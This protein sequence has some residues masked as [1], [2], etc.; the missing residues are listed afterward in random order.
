MFRAVRYK[1]VKSETQTS[2]WIVAL[3]F[4][5]CA[6]N[7]ED[8][9]YKYVLHTLHVAQKSLSRMS[10]WP[11]SWDFLVHYHS[12]DVQP[13]PHQGQ[14]WREPVFGAPLPPTLIF[15]GFLAKPRAALDSGQAVLLRWSGWFHRHRFSFC[16]RLASA[17]A[18]ALVCCLK[19]SVHFSV[20]CSVCSGE[21]TL[22]CFKSSAQRSKSCFYW[23]YWRHQCSYP[24]WP[25]F[26]MGQDAINISF[27]NACV[28]L[29]D[30]SVTSSCWTW[31]TKHI[32]IWS[33][34]VYPHRNIRKEYISPI[35]LSSTLDILPTTRKFCSHLCVFLCLF[36]CRTAQKVIN[37]WFWWNPLK[38]VVHID[39]G[40]HPGIFWIIS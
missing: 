14:V 30:V 11:L 4:F 6:V 39:P 22:C 17:C 32:S 34:S 9:L 29:P 18:P 3:T 24:F 1:T 20:S 5:L 33:F 35:H 26:I 7:I 37:R 15:L 38:L 2:E 8:R 13:A 10:P 36:V 25:K 40:V 16:K 28:C 27:I 21:K 23:E 31:C 19:S 12:A